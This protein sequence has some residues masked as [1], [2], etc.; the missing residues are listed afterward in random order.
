MYKYALVLTDVAKLGTKTFSYL[1]PDSM[2]S[3][4]KIGQPVSVP[5]GPKRKIKGYIAGFSNYLEEGI[6]AKYIDEIL[7]TEPL[8]TLEYL[9]LLEWVANYYFCD[10]PTVLKTALPQK[11]FEKNVKN[12]RKPRKENAA[13]QKNEENKE[14]K[15]SPEQQKVYEEIKHVN[16]PNSLLYGITGSGKTEIYFKLIEDTI[17][18]GKNVLFMAPEIALVSQLTMRTIKRFGA[19]KVAIWHSSISEAEK[20]SVWQKLRQNEIKILFGARS[21]VFA[22]IKNLGLIIIDEEHDTSYKQTMPNPRYCAKHVAKE[23]AKLHG[24]K[25][26]SGSATPDVESFWE[27]QNTNSLFELKN[28]YNNAQLPDVSIVDMKS[29]RIDG[30]LGIFSRTLINRTKET[31]ERGEQVIFLINRRGFSTYTQCMEC[32]QVLECKKCAIPLIYHSQTNSWRCHYCGYEV[33]HPKCENCGS[34][35]LENFGTGSQ[36]VEE[37]AKKIFE[38]MSVARLDSDSLNKKNEHIEILQKF[39][40]GGINILIGTQMIAKGL[41]NPNVTLV[42][43]INADLSFNLPDYRSSERGFS[44]LTQVAGRSGR[45]G[46]KGKVIFQTYN[47]QNLFLQKAKEQDYISFF[48]KEKELRQEYDYPPYSKIIR[49]IISSKEEFKAEHACL[50]ITTHLENYIK[51]LSLDERIIVLGPTPCV[52]GKIRGEWRYNILIKNKLEQK[53]HDTVLGF[54]RKIILPNDIKMITD[55]DPSDIL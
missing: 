32:A 28:R 2:R 36:R 30:N 5:F 19:D 27:A 41:D 40:N 21:A 46:H 20:Y 50:E 37:I 12:Y 43:V 38:G 9:K 11:F 47:P 1:I 35:E 54:L 44:L 14:H 8:F 3:D 42:G 4:I 6:K 10:L 22:P 33:K 25:I 52:I 49:I 24:A 34:E 45:G 17:K 13:L 53:G 31:I 26:I 55:V 18:E 29:E 39:Q 7:D 15:L 16:A 48:E 51:K 23:L